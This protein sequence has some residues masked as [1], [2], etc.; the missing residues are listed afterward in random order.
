MPGEQDPQTSC[1]KCAKCCRTS[2]PTLYAE[3][4]EGIRGGQLDR[5]RLY[6]LRAGEMV[7]SSRLDRDM[8]LEQD[9]VKVM[10][11]RE[12]GCAFLDGDLCSVHPHH[13][14]QCR[15]FECWSSRNAGDLEGR[16][17]LDRRDLFKDDG[18]AL[19]LIAEY[20]VKVPAARLATLLAERSPEA[21][22]LID[23]DYRLRGGMEEKLGYDQTVLG[24]M[25]G[26]P[27]IVV[28]RAH[29]LDV[30]VDEDGKPVLLDTRHSQ[31]S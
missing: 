16:A 18:T 22:D 27:A 14:L 2:S 26:R 1:R 21:I 10:E 30:S 25:L 13:P 15:H 28:A 19:Q 17:R 12:G 8:A 11:G 24:L 5:L 20:D 23:L 6:T 7:H 4:E 29:G 9:L 3:D 31:Q